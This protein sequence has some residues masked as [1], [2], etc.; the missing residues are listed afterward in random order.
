MNLVKNLLC[1]QM[2]EEA[3]DQLISCDTQEFQEDRHTLRMIT[4]NDVKEVEEKV[5]SKFHSSSL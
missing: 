2:T 1:Y 3:S 4:E 5:A